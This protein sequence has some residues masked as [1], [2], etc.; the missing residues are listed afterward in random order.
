MYLKCHI[1][2]FIVPL[3]VLVI[4]QV[5]ASESLNFCFNATLEGTYTRDIT[6]LREDMDWLSG[7]SNIKSIYLSYRIMF[8]LLL[9]I[10]SV[11]DKNVIIIMRQQ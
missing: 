9:H 2:L 4:I 10:L 3:V 7:H 11:V 8:Y 1:L 6:R 5:Q